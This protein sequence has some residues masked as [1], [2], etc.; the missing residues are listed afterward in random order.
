MKFNIKKSQNGQ[1]LVAVIALMLLS[2]GLGVSIS[3]S[4]MSR[5]KNQAQT[6]DFSKAKAA[7]DAELERLLVIPNTTLSDY[8]TGN[9]CGSVCTWQITD[10]N[11]QLITA[12]ATLSYAGNTTDSFTADLMTTD[13]F[14]L[15]LSGYT[16]AKYVDVCWDSPASIYASYIKSAAGVINSKAYAHNAVNTLYPENGFSSSTAKDGHLSCFTVTATDTPIM[17][18]LKSYYLNTPVYIIPEAGQ[19]LPVQ[20]ITIS[21]VGH[22]GTA[23]AR[24]S[25][26]KTAATLPPLFD[27]AIFQKSEDFPLSNVTL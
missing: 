25:A 19:V 26:L 27:Y 17:V 16:S 7:A 24:T 11:G 5:L 3:S 8:I 1:I 6:D 9:S 20:G 4:L 21:V 22:A 14:Q 2:L 12:Q 15:L 18:R 23:T 13:V 10:T